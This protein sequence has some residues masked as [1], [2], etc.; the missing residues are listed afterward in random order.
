LTFEALN[1]SKE[2]KF[3]AETEIENAV[4]CAV[5]IISLVPDSNLNKTKTNQIK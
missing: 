2:D 3:L 4:N 1:P 5:A